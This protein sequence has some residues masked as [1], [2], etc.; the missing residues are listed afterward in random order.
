VAGELHVCAVSSDGR[1]WHTIRG[2]GGR[3]KPFADVEGEAGEQG[4]FTCA[5][6]GELQGLLHVGGVTTNGEQWHTIRAFDGTRP[7][8]FG[9]T[10][11]GWQG[12]GDVGTQ[13]TQPGTF[14]TVSVDGL[15]R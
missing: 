1:L 2:A 5:S 4:T 11:R 13:A 6:S 8:P 9:Q 3:W 7:L 10:V 14:T 12:F 15:I